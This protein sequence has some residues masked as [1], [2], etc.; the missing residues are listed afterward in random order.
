MKPYDVPHKG[1]RNALSQLQLLAGKTDYTDQHEVGQLFNLAN[2]VFKILSIHAKDEDAVTL[3]ELEKKCPGCSKHDME[4]HLQ[5]HEMQNKLEKLLSELYA[6]SRNGQDSTAA[7][8][9]FYL[10]L[11]EYHGVYLEHTAEEERVTQPLLWKFFAD[12]ELATH[13]SK[14]MQSNPPE[15]LLIW[16]RFVLPAQSHAE[17]VGLLT[18]FKKMAPKALFNSGMDVIRKALSKE[19]FKKLVA[20][21]P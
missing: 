14:I 10:S 4:D 21:L 18:G 16:F 19:D 1:L 5:L 15:T 11:S 8:A 2:D 13:R 7:G 20:S 6:K 12:E 9:E 3:T 17:R